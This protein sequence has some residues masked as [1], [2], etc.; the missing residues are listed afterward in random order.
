[1]ESTTTHPGPLHCGSYHN[2]HQT[3]WIPVLR[4]YVETPRHPV[5]LESVSDDGWLTLRQDGQELRLWHHDVA[6]VRYLE[7]RQWRRVGDT[8][9]LVAGN[10]WV[11]CGREPSPCPETVHPQPAD[12]SIGFTSEELVRLSRER[13]GLMIRGVDLAPPMNHVASA[14]TAVEDS[15]SFRPPSV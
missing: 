15:T 6:H 1:M 4:V 14:E 9:F 13:G 10:S 7:R 2:G 5:S 12:R 8:S 3:H 11:C